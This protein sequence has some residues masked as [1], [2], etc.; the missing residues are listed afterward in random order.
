MQPSFIIEPNRIYLSNE[1]GIK[2][3]EVTF[4]SLPDGKV[5]INHTFVDP[6][7][8]GQ[9]I[10]GQLMEAAAKHL[11]ASGIQAV[12]TCSYAIR[13]FDQHPEYQDIL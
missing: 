5:E 4:P 9:G 8:R 7:L 12:P 3:A 6:S 11:R 10:A 2:V 1:N 13:W